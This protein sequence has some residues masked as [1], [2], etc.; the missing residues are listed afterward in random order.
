MKMPE[1]SDSPQKC[2]HCGSTS[3]YQAQANAKGGYGPDLLPGLGGFWLGAKF[4][5]VL[6][7]ECG[8]TQFFADEKS[9]AKLAQSNKWTRL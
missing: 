8:A 1:K 7:S 5:V 2:P 9:R 3:L 4:R 6:C